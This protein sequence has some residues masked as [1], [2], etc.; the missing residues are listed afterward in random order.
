MG[1]LLKEEGLLEPWES[2]MERLR[3]EIPRL[4]PGWTDYNIHD[5]GITVLELF[6]W[7]RQV[8]MYHASRI[9]PGHLQKFGGHPGD[10]AGPQDAGARAGHG[11]CAGG[12]GDRGGEPV[13]CR[14]DLF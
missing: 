3:E 4:Y 10:P 1:T 5:P 9:G 2:V 7:M 6:A 14:G 11:G 8:Q 12:K 13:L